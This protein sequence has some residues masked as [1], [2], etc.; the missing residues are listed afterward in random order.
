MNILSFV[1]FEVYY[2]NDL[3]HIRFFRRNTFDVFNRF[4]MINDFLFLSRVQRSV[5]NAKSISINLRG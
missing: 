3:L 1:G 2:K 4:S 5:T